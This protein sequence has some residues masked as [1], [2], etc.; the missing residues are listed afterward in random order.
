M[1]SPGTLGPSLRQG[2]RR[3]SK[4]RGEAEASVGHE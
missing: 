4:C 3:R 2:P 1:D